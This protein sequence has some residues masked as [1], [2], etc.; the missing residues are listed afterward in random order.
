MYINLF[1][2][3]V[4]IRTIKVSVLYDMHE[5]SNS[6]FWEISIRW[7]RHIVKVRIFEKVKK[8]CSVDSPQQKSESRDT[9][10]SWDCTWAS[11]WSFPLMEVPW[12]KG[13]T[14]P[15]APGWPG[16]TW[17]CRVV[18]SCTTGL[19]SWAGNNIRIHLCK[20]RALPRV[21][22]QSEKAIS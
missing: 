14:S 12:G 9:S 8:C 15:E 20:I 19:G 3:L 22:R 21:T 6:T 11:A 1:N 18:F 5:R 13:E 17:S 10:A 2:W 7:Q 16:D 4:K